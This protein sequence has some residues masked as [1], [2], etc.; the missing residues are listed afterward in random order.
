MVG[1][2]ER[3]EIDSVFDLSFL[4]GAVLLINVA[5][6][7]LVRELVTFADGELE[8][9]GLED[10]ALIGGQAGLFGAASEDAALS[11]QRESAEEQED[12]RKGQAKFFA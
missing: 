5:D 2:V 6:I 8:V 4:L 7:V 11:T 3:D 9:A 10:S 1:E 12:E